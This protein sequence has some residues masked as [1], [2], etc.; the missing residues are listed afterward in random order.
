M[1]K[2][3][4]GEDRLRDARKTF[5]TI[6]DELQEAALGLIAARVKEEIAER[7]AAPKVMDCLKGK[8]PYCEDVDTGGGSD[9]WKCRVDPD[10]R[11]YFDFMGRYPC[12]A[13]LDKLRANPHA[14]TLFKDTIEIRTKQEADQKRYEERYRKELDAAKI[15]VAAVISKHGKYRVQEAVEELTR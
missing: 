15:D 14:A 6:P 12:K 9:V 4:F 3:T 7:E 11:I 10:V 13:D 1:S 8:C 2:P 5:R